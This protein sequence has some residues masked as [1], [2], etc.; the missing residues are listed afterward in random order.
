M[1]QSDV[2]FYGTNSCLLCYDIC[3]NLKKKHIDISYALVCLVPSI[4]LICQLY[5]GITSYHYVAQA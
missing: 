5:T 1:S 3:S 4:Y 2:P